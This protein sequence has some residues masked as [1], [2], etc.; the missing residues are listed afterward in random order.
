MPGY[1][2]QKK[3][4]VS[5]LFLFLGKDFRA[6]ITEKDHCFGAVDASAVRRVRP[7]SAF[8][9]LWT[10]LPN[11]AASSSLKGDPGSAGTELKP[12]Q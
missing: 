8:L 10:Q 2:Y 7:K 11:P 12:P 9:A 4:C 1:S 5:I 6:T 3:K